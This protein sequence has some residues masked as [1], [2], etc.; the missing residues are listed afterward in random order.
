MVSMTDKKKNLPPPKKKKAT[1]T[2]EFHS[3]SCVSRDTENIIKQ[4]VIQILHYVL[5]VVKYTFKYTD[6]GIQA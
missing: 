5:R 1:P 2:A 3:F 4:C 6:I